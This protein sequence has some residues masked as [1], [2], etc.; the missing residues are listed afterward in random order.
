MADEDDS[1]DKTEDP[2]QKRLDEALERGDVAKSQE[3]NTWFMIAGATLV[4]SSFS[5]SIGSL[6]MPLR[7]LLANAWMFHTDGPSLLDLGRQLE[8]VVIAALGVPFLMLIISAI[9]GNMLQHRLVWSGESL[10]PSLKKIS[11][12][13]G[14]KRIFGKQAAANF[15]KGIFK[16]VALG[17]VMSVI[18]WPEHHRLESM[19][20]FEP[21]VIIGVISGLTLHLLGAVVAILAAVAIA[22]YFFQYRQWYERRKM[23]L[24]DIKKEFK[25]SEGDPHVK[26]RIRQLRQARMRK[27]M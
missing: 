21:S 27:R 7:N 14:L 10:K 5:G 1:S 26:G 16:L 9:A 24:Q 8:Y 18:L 17:T 15:G 22:D 2:T 19:V 13:S 23:S 3:V 11:P 12:A 25:Q 6:Q 20:Q 4:L